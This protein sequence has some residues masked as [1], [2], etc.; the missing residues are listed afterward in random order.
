MHLGHA[1]SGSALRPHLPGRTVRSRLTL[2]Y[3]GLFVGCGVVP[4]II[5]A[6]LW[7][8]ATEGPVT[9]SAAV[10]KRILAIGHR[11]QGAYVSGTARA[12]KQFLQ[13]ADQLKLF[14]TQ[15]HSSDLR[16]LVLYS[17]VSLAIMAMLS[18][19]LSWLT[20]GRVLRPLRT[21]TAAVR[22]ISA[23]NLHERLSV[24]GPDDELRELGATFDQ[25]LERLDGSFR[26]QRRFVANAS[27]ELRTPLATMRAII[28]VAV[29]KPGTAP[30]Q[31]VVLADRLRTALDHVDRLLEG[32]LLLAR[33][34][35]ATVPEDFP[36]SLD[37]LAASALE[38]R[39]PVI[40]Q[41]SLTVHDEARAEAWVT[42]NETLLGRMVENLVDNAVRH[43]E[44]AGWIRV[45]TELEGAKARLIV[46]NSGPNLE[47]DSI[48][49]LAV[50][51]RRH[52]A[53]RTGSDDGLGLGLSIVSS[54][55][56]THRGQLRL[57]ALSG[58]GLRVV[59]E[60]PLA[61]RE[62]FQSPA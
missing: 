33:A 3:G 14:A 15:Q 28:D 37:R 7:G 62:L 45:R 24:R 42:G 17:A 11:N 59:V 12:P 19:V 53:E 50:P 40:S 51:F 49:D 60:L 23:S 46:E 25:L 8:R 4:L 34:Q 47:G 56:E 36:L 61:V 5:T 32:F 6:V 41:M 10:P 2:L 54:I 43:N 44:Q 39:E 55:A 1:R 35:A 31:T 57:H 58:G 16:Q 9:F 21:M 29:A 30:A 22:R 52:G 26:A 27:H 18:V 20:A 38:D 48:M 13:V